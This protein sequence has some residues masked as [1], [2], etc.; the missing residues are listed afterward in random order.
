MINDLLGVVVLPGLAWVAGG[1]VLVE[2]N[3]P[4]CQPASDRIDAKQRGQLGQGCESVGVPARPVVVGA[5][6]NPK[7]AMMS[8]TSL[9]Q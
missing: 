9:M 6:D 4:I 5:I 3:E 1:V 8:L 7:N 2:T